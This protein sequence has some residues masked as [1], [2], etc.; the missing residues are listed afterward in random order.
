MRSRAA[1]RKIGEF[2]GATVVAPTVSPRTAAAHERQSPRSPA[3][4]LAER[5]ERPEIDQ[6]D[7]DDVAP[8]AQG[9][10]ELGKVFPELRRRLRRRDRQEQA[11]DEGSDASRDQPVADPNEPRRQ[12]AETAKMPEHKHIN[13]DGEGLHREL[14][15]REIRRA[16][17][18]EHHGDAVADGAE[19]EHGRHRRSRDGCGNRTG[20]DDEH[21]EDVVRP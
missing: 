6:D 9:R 4:Y 13:E 10:S 5:I 12:R 19:G 8:V 11:A 14:C 18:E 17:A 3:P 20:D 16:E 7:V 15:H 21:D 1:V 2:T